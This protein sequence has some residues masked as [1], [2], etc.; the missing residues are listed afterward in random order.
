MKTK[1]MANNRFK[2]TPGSV[3]ALRG[4]ALGAAA[5][6]AALCRKIF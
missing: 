4:K 1:K 2:R 3:A 5:Y 6:T